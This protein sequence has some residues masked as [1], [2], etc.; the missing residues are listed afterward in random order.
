MKV[1][2][3]TS[4]LLL[5]EIVPSDKAGLFEMDSDPEVHRYLGNQPVTSLQQIEEVI[6]H[7]RRQ[8][9]DYGIARWAVIEKSS[10]AFIGWAGLKFITEP[11]NGHVE[12]YD[13]GYRFMR[14]HWGKGF[15]SEAAGACV[16][17]GF[18]TLQL[19]MICAITDSGNHASKNVL[20]KNGFE[21]TGTFDLE[22]VPHDW[23]QL[24]KVEG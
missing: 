16:L 2:A 17:Y 21:C 8:Y 4:R 3:E 20:R 6:V 11:I 19:Q 24:G 13:L 14:K 22:E 5:R 7:I 10:N 23:F 18:E 12:Y 9:A 1:F 15:A